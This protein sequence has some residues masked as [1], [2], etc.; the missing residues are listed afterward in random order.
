MTEIALDEKEFQEIK[1]QKV[2]KPLMWFGIV[3]IIMFFAGLTSAVLVRKGDGDWVGFELPSFF[4]WSTVVIVLSSL[5][6]IFAL[7]SAKKDQFQNVKYG[8]SATMILGILFIIF[9]FKGFGELIQQGIYLT[10]TDQSASGSF[11]YVIAVSHILHLLGG[12]IAMIFVLIKSMKNKYNSKNLLGLQ[13][14]S[15]YWHFLGGMW[16]Y[17]YVF[18]RVII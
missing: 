16:I 14:S 5:T 9:Q 6:L 1:R 3:G 17:L 8:V 15:I 13:V 4:I 11:V 12:I 10:G 7:R 18:F 2:A